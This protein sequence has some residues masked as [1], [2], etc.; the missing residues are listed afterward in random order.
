LLG[1]V[2]SCWESSGASSASATISL[3]RFLIFSIVEPERMSSALATGAPEKTVSVFAV[4]LE[5]ASGSAEVPA[6]QA[7]T[8]S[9]TAARMAPVKT[10]R[11]RVVRVVRMVLRV[12]CIPF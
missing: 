11:R 1:S 7:V 6:E 8:A 9:V 2:G 10:A 12:M 5:P 4:E 3:P